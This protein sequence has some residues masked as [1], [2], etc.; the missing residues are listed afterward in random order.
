MIEKWFEPF[1]LLEKH[2]TPDG[3]GGERISFTD[4]L[5]FSG[6]LTW[7]GNETITAAERIALEESPALLHEFDVTLSPGDH[8]RREKDGA[9]YKVISPSGSLRTPVFS[10]LRFAQ[11][12]VERVVF[13]C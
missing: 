9:V 13:P 6:V 10:G 7:T 8:V 2:A 5:P 12:Q 11:V 3:L 1:T 4:E